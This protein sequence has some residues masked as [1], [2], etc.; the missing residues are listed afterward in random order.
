LEG[1]FIVYNEP[2]EAAV[3][4]K[5]FSHIKQC[6]PNVYV[7]FN[8]DSF[9]WPFIEARA[10][11]NNMSLMREIGVR[12]DTNGEYKARFASH[13]D[14]LCWVIRDSYLPQGSHG[15]KKVTKAKLG[16]DPL[17][18]DPEDMLKF[19]QEKPQVRFLIFQWIKID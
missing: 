18:L 19:A 16:Y 4:R 5:W 2:D 1:P 8:G 14:A 7:S 11:F 15:L 12:K 6:K 13:M 9:D 17:E 3:L 10:R